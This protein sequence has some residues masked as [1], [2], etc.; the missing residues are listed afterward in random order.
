M[1][2]SKY[3]VGESKRPEPLIGA[4]PGQFYQI[5]G[6]IKLATKGK[7]IGLLIEVPKNKDQQD[8]PSPDKY[9]PHLPNS[10]RNIINYRSQRSEIRD[11]AV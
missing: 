8:F 11:L 9:N 5:G 2:G 7:T 1:G 6:D 3:T 4:S 10:A